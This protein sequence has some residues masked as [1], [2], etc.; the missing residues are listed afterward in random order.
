MLKRW[1]KIR[2][3][4]FCA[5]VGFEIATLSIYSSLFDMISFFISLSL[6][7]SFS[8]FLSLSILTVTSFLNRYHT[9][10]SFP[11]PFS[12]S[13]FPLF[14]LPLI[15][16]PLSFPSQFPQLPGHGNH[17][18]ISRLNCLLTLLRSPYGSVLTF[19]LCYSLPLSLCHSWEGT[20]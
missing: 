12:F 17:I 13:F 20:S 7:S 10:I 4:P 14:F 3:A 18:K 15:L 11:F 6:L 2:R 16:P 5:A 19:Q 1:K 9:T 8:S